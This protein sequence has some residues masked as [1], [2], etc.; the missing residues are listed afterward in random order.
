[1]NEAPCPTFSGSEASDE[2]K[3]CGWSE[4]AHDGANA[5]RAYLLLSEG[6]EP[7]AALANI[8]AQVRQLHHYG[9]PPDGR[10]QADVDADVKAIMDVV[11]SLTAPPSGSRPAP[12]PKLSFYVV[13]DGTKFLQKDSGSGGYPFEVAR[14]E[15]AWLARDRYNLAN[16][17]RVVS[18][19]GKYPN[20]TVREVRAAIDFP[21]SPPSTP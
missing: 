5:I 16:W 8:E 3:H 9:Y 7:G 6:R 17:L 11:R 18:Y 2:C 13:S 10:L 15:Q 1:M 20:Y 14:I 19:G 12:S 4:C 21:S